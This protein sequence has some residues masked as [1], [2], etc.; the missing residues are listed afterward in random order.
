MICGYAEILKHSI[1]KDRNFFHWLCKNG[2]EILSNRKNNFIQYAIIKS[3]KIKSKIVELDENEKNLRKVLNFG[4]T[5]AHAFESLNNY[6]RNLNHGEAVL[7]GMNI[8]SQFA[9]QKKIMPV[10]ELYLI[11][12]HLLNLNLNY[13]IKKYLKKNQINKLLEFMKNDKK[14][15][16]NK[17]NLILSK[18]IGSCLNSRSYSVNEIKKFLLNRIK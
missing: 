3:C 1:I 12:K 11:Q 16:S 9:Y 8:A 5:F 7:L 4:H 15:F 14:N 6:S 18:K 10:K 17:I 2:K 13:E